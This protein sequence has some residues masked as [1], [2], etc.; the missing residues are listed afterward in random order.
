M[1]WTAADIPNLI[2]KTAVIT[3]ANSGLGLESTMALAAAGAHVVMAARDQD[4]ADRAHGEIISEVP[5]ASLEIVKLDLGSLDSVSDAARSITG[6]HVRVDILMNN[7]GVM[8]LPERRTADGFEFQFGVNHLGHWA[9]TAQLLRPLLQAPE[10]R[11]VTV[12]STARHFGRPVDPDNPHL[13]D[14]YEEWRAYGQ[15]K[16]ANLHFAVGLQQEFARRGLPARSLVAHPGLSF[17]NLQINTVE[18]GGGGRS[19]HFWKDLAAKRGMSASRG[20]LPQ[21]RASTDPKARG[22]QLYA[23]RYGNWGPPVRRPILR[24][25]GMERAIAALWLVS[26]QETGIELDFDGAMAGG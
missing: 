12:S 25:I 19:G 5:D 10:A 3:G 18:Q 1:S 15:S 22:G 13:E 14:R 4:K 26:E 20:A 7:A 24:R 23:P 2:G 6:S 11:V 9:L 8:A 17:T 16:L 21:L